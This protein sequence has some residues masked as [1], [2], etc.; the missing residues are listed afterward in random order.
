MRVTFF[1]RE[2]N[3]EFSIERVFDNIISTFDNKI[4]YETKYVHYSKITISNVINNIIYCKKNSNAVNHITGDIYYCMLGLSSK[5]TV[6]T[7]HDLGIVHNSKGIKKILLWFFWYYLPIKKAKYVTCI[8]EQT[9]IELIKST[10]CSEKK[11][12]VIPNP[13][14]KNYIPTFKTFNHKKPLI[15]HIGTRKN[16][17]LER[18]II[19]LKDIECTLRIIGVLTNEQKKILNKNK[20][21]FSNASKLSDDEIM[22]EYINCDIVSFPSLYEGFGMPI[23]EAQAIGRPVLTSNISPLKQISN[24]STIL[25][26]PYDV[27]SITKGF[28]E[29]ITNEELRN[30]LITRGLANS[31]KYTA[32]SIAD[33]YIEI[34]KKIINQQ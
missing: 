25:I 22:K 12:I 5:N 32:I 29:L 17:N 9:K 34:Y 26:N 18:V 31:E 13:V 24:N 15:L 7:F 21:H 11:I 4:T 6:I 28:K 23:I 14:S 16:K 1:F 8:S 3:Y 30:K 10:K 33:K 2:K 27:N 19:A 20:I